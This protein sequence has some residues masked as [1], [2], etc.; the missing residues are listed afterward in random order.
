MSDKHVSL[1]E[2][3]SFQDFNTALAHY[4]PEVL[5]N[6]AS[7][8]RREVNDSVYD[9]FPNPI[10]RIPMELILRQ[11][12]DFL[13]DHGYMKALTQEQINAAKVLSTKQSSFGPK[14]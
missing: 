8:V 11:K 3:Q 4:L 5:K 7:N 14:N 13:R 2:L 10:A 1:A 6:L 12:Y 9:S